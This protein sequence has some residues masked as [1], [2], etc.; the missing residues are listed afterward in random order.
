LRAARLAWVSGERGRVVDFAVGVVVVLREGFVAA[1]R[2]GGG[3][4]V[5]SSQDA[6]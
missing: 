6:G 3:I 2:V 5:G 1:G 4:V